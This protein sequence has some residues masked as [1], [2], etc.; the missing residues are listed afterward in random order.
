MYNIIIIGAGVVGA[1]VARRLARYKLDILVLEKENDVGDGASSANSAIVHSGYDPEPGT[2]KA[3]LN[4][5]G[6]KM[7]DEICADLDVEMERIGSLTLSNS[8]EDD[9]TLQDLLERAKI[10]GVE[11]RLV[12]RE[13]LKEMEPNITSKAR[14]ALFA[15]S[16]GIINPFELVV[17]L[18]EN[19]MDNGV[20]LHLSEEVKS[21]EKKD[22]SYLVKTNK[23]EYETDYVI[24]CA[25]LYSDKVS[26][27]VNPKFFTIIPKRGEYYVLDHFDNNYVKHT[28]FNVPSAKGKG[29]LVSPTTHYNYLVGPSSE[30]VDERDDV[31]TDAET[32]ANVKE[33][34]YDLV[35]NLR[36][37]KQIRQFAGMRAVSD[38]NHGDFII[39]ETSH[40]FI[41]CAGIQSPGLASS[42]AIALM[43]DEMIKDKELKENYNPKRRPLY[44]LNKLSFEDRQILIKENPLFGHIVC[45][46]EKVSEAEVIDAI[47]RN[48]GART[49]KGVKKRVRPGFGKCQGGFCEPLI[50]N[51]LAKELNKDKTEITYGKDGSYILIGSTKGE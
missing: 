11:A 44:R 29:V 43:V 6:N 21:I 9:K 38:I 34:A 14:G 37:D 20:K 23:G 17:A 50:L 45:R 25:G 51:I 2:L 5:L 8:E 1:Q 10:N 19:A 46:C 18:M 12:S 48:C 3:K 35:D 33:K 41:N 26:E 31:S 4:V 40:H 30:V 15:P 39:E 32:L 13:E 42:P 47:R 24:N 36:M 7:Y 22:N 28:L 16:A 49:I 27:M